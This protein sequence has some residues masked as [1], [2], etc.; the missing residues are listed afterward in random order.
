MAT[1]W[2][3]MLSA[4]GAAFLTAAGYTVDPALVTMALVAGIAVGCA[5]LC[6]SLLWQR[7][8]RISEPGS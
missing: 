7:R 6:S 4:V 8:E 5:A 3:I 2:V 1:P